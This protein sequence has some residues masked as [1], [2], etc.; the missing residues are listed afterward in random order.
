MAP[1]VRF[2]HR[3]IQH[4]RYLFIT[5]QES[6]MWGLDNSRAPPKPPFLW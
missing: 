4:E 2:Y 5:N 1:N 3:D 6:K